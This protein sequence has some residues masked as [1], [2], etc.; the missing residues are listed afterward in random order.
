MKRRSKK[1]EFFFKK[2]RVGGRV[3]RASNPPLGRS[4][5][6]GVDDKLVGCGIKGGSGLETWNVRSV[7][8]LGHG[9]AAVHPLQC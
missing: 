4:E 1:K 2:V 5:R 9:K 6:G 7:S 3:S 8:Q